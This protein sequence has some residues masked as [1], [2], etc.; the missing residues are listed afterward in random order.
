MHKLTGVFA[1]CASLA[2]CGGG[3]GS[4]GGSP[5][6]APT[7]APAPVT[8]SGSGANVALTGAVT[9]D[10]VPISV[11]GN[12]SSRLNYSSVVQRPARSVVVEVI[13]SSSQ[14]VLAT[15]STNASGVYQL[16]AIAGGRS[17]FVRA[18][19]K[20]TSSGANTADIA[21][22]D[23]TN[24][25]AQWATD[26]AAFC[27]DAAAPTKSLNAG[28]GWTGSAYNDGARAAG[29][30]A[31]L[32]TI[33]LATQKIVSVDAS[34]Q[35][36]TLRINWSP[37][38][39]ATNGT[40]AN[41]QIGTSFYTNA[42]VNGV[43]SRNLY[44]LGR[45]DNDTD[46]YDD[47]VIAHEFGHYLQDVFSRD[48]TIGGAHG[49]LDDRLDMRVAFSEGWGNGW[50]GI[51]LANPVYADTSGTQQAQGASFNVSTGETTNPGFFK[52]A[53]VEKMFWDFSQITATTPNTT[54]GFAR[55]WNTMKNFMKTTPALT[56]IHSFTSALVNSGGAPGAA[57]QT[58][59]T[60]QNI[61]LPSDAYGSNETNF[62]NPAIANLNP[63]YL[64][65][66]ALNSTLGS[67][68]VSNATDT[69][70]VG[71]KAGEHRY[72][73]FSI[74]AG[75]AQSRTITVTQSS[76]S[77]G[78]SDPDF[79]VYDSTGQIQQAESN[80]ARSETAT[81]TLSSGNYVLAITDYGLVSSIG[82]SSSCFT[83][84][85]R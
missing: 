21:V 20:M 22:I 69:A 4:N 61:A 29:P 49:G 30:F 33:Y 44:I 8:C 41:G 79:T 83:L 53:S 73:R 43:P 34:V 78:S 75:T 14:Q 51:A 85:I 55:V 36:P 7:P 5:A 65:Y 68:C 72:V 56:G 67:I 63:I 47:H 25:G 50:S 35:F 57:V 71:N 58:I 64:S 54:I 18:K 77:S 16:S 60:A 42:S 31:I 6:P 19:A 70:K 76:S 26:T 11:S 59:L 39:I 45:Q 48:D 24:G 1:L 37:N 82:N 81:L 40:L 38:N 84:N 52:E 15:A 80:V 2:A 62:G 12:G 28:S 27:S 9:F 66:G 17:V 46:E 74:P 3:G 13:D 32:D 10:Y 23:N